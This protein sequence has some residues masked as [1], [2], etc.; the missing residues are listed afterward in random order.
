[1]DLFRDV[2]AV[3]FIQDIAE[4]RYVIV[5]LHGVDTVV[6]GDVSNAVPGEEVLDQMTG[7]EII[8]SETAEILCNDEINLLVLTSL[9]HSLKIRTIHIQ[10]GISVVLKYG[11][12]LPSIHLAKLLEHIAL[13]RY[14]G[15]LSLQFV[16]LGQTAVDR[17][18]IFGGRKAP[19]VHHVHHHNQLTNPAASFR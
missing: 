10:A 9:E 19:L 4:G 17:G 13:I 2:L 7:L 8:A 3:K 5:V 15:A 6:H 1:M 14:A 11:N 16:V 12:D 18:L